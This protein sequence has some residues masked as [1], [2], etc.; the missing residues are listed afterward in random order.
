[1]YVLFAYKIYISQQ[2]E[3]RVNTSTSVFARRW[4]KYTVNTM[5]FTTKGKLFR[6]PSKIAKTQPTWC[7]LGA[8]KNATKRC[9]VRWSQAAVWK[10]HHIVRCTCARAK[11]TWTTPTLTLLLYIPL[12]A[13]PKCEALQL[14]LIFDFQN[15]LA[16]PC[17]LKEVS[18]DT[19]WWYRQPTQS[20]QT[21][22]F[23]TSPEI[24]VMVSCLATFIKVRPTK[25][26]TLNIF[27][28]DVIHCRKMWI[29]LDNSIRIQETH[30]TN[31]AMVRFLF[32][33]LSVQ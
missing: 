11:S 15:V 27:A 22:G 14:P 26:S 24:F 16:L 19:I 31:L 5:H 17:W 30:D 10:E 13:S 18:L 2:A 6:K 23:P 20:W 8:D 12:M 3:N 28:P 1:L 29:H 9:V 4:L 25:N 33:H 32:S 7:F 21:H